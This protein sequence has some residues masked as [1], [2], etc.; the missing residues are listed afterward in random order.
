MGRPSNT[1]L[2]LKD[3]LMEMERLCEG[4]DDAFGVSLLTFPGYISSS[5]AVMFA[6]HVNQSVTLLNPDFPRVFTN[7]ENVFGDLSSGYYKTKSN[8]KVIK[9]VS[10]YQD[11]P[12]YLYN[13]FIW[14]PKGWR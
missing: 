14:N 1:N 3:N 10:R 8:I 9:R 13:L 5:R 4:N 12:N 2:H 11:K 6:S 7:Y